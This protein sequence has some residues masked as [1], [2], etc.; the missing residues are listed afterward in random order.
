MQNYCSKANIS[1]KKN[2]FFN[3]AG[4][5]LRPQMGYFDFIDVS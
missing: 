1:D 4:F 2:V 3:V 5:F